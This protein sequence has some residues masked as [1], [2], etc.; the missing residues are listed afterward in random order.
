MEFEEEEEYM[1]V[2]NLDMVVAT[3]V[4]ALIGNG[5][6]NYIEGNYRSGNYSGFGNY[7]QQPSNCG[8]IQRGNFDGG[9]KTMG[10]DM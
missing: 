1:V 5:Y 7:N 9:S 8:S 3:R 4:G 10:R 6:D 2:E